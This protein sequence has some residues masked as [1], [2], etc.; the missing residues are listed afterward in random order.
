MAEA[1]A[2]GIAQAP[3]A[4]PMEAAEGVAQAPMPA[5]ME[6]AE[7]IARAPTVAPMEVAGVTARDR[8]VEAVVTVQDLMGE[9]EVT[10]RVRA[11]VIAAVRLQDH[12]RDRVGPIP[13]SGCWPYRNRSAGGC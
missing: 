10:A 8:T 6:A 4:V 3:M 9:A 7:G 11:V 2:E 13:I 1:T 12:P 5:P